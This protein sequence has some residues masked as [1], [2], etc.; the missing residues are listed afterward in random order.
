VRG[1][2]WEPGMRAGSDRRAGLEAA[3]ARLARFAGAERWTL[4]R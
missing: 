4:P 1:L 2:W 3:V